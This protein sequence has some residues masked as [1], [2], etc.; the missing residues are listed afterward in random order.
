MPTYKAPTRDLQFVLHDVLGVDD[1][2]TSLPE[3]EE[4]SPDLIDA[5]LEQGAKF[6]ED[7]LAPLNESGDEEGCQWTPEGVKTPAGFAQAY[8][9]YVE[10]GWPS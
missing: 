8:G 9:Q 5:I 7:V 6:C 1:V 4:V 10:G 3:F 2:Y